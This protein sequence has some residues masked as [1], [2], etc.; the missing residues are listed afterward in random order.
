MR[1]G[2][3]LAA[4][5]DGQTGLDARRSPVAERLQD[6]PGRFRHRPGQTND[7]FQYRAYLRSRGLAKNP[8]ASTNPL[9]VEWHAFREDRDD[10]AWKWLTDAI[11]AYA[12]AQG[13]RVLINANG[14][15]RYVDLQVLGV[16][17]NWRTMDGRIDLSESQLDDWGSTVAAGWGMAGRKIPALPVSG[18]NAAQTRVSSIAAIILQATGPAMPRG[19]DSRSTPPHPTQ[20]GGGTRG[21]SASA[22]LALLSVVAFQPRRFLRLGQIAVGRRSPAALPWSSCGGLANAVVAVDRRLAT[23]RSEHSGHFSRGSHPGDPRNRLRKARPDHRGCR[24]YLVGN[25]QSLTDRPRWTIIL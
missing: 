17:G 6:R 15:A 23:P 10:R 7:S 1:A 22:C 14:L 13:R 5:Y 21:A 19:R 18:V 16:W 8:H 3:I 12:A 11:R 9:A 2:A 25:V 24:E 4:S 20:G